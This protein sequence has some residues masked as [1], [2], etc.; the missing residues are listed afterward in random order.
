MYRLFIVIFVHIVSGHNGYDHEVAK[1][2]SEHQVVPNVISVPPKQ[3]LK[4]TY[5][6]NEVKFGNEL[7]PTQVK[8]IPSV[9]WNADPTLFYTL[10]MTDPD[11]PSRQNPEFGEWIHW[12]VVNIP[13]KDISKGDTIAEYVGSGP[14]PH[15]DLHRYVFLVYAQ[16]HK[17]DF[18]EPILTNKSGNGRA[19]GSVKKF[20]EKHGL[21]YPLFGNFYQA[22]YDDYVPI[23]YKQLGE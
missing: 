16:E 15:T 17:H 5:G 23:L 9:E 18:E 11:A 19:K 14:P 3:G 8:D 7:T 10:I 4:V 21:G 2:F 1:Y 12:I 6:E 13:G 20:A 22:K